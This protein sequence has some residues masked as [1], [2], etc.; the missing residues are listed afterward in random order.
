MIGA[1]ADAHGV[2][3]Q[4][5]QHRGGLSRIEDAHPGPFHGVHKGP[6]QR[7]DSAKALQES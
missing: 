6:R 4:G 2:F 1:A 7:R 3:L 5:A